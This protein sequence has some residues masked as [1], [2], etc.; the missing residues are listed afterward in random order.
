M[1]KIHLIA[2]VINIAPVEP[3]GAVINMT[4]R[5]TVL[6]VACIFFQGVRSSGT[7]WNTVVFQGNT[8]I[9]DSS[10]EPDNNVV[11]SFILFHWYF[12]SYLNGN[13]HGVISSVR[14]SLYW[15]TPYI[16]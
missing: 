11:I 1:C 2:R 13:E 3:N 15:Q 5:P 6:V 9:I 8:C 7:P 16:L 10:L 12:F 14:H 4:L